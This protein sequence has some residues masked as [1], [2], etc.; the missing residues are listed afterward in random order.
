VT[1]DMATSHAYT[2]GS[3]PAE[4]ARLQGQANDLAGHTAT[5]LDK[6]E[7]PPGGRALDLGCGPAGSIA[8]LADRVGPSGFVTAIDID[9]AHV[10]MARRFVGNQGFNHVEVLQGDARATGLPSG[11]FDLVHARLLL[12]NIP[13]PEQVMAEMARLVKPGGW[14]VTD[15]ADAGARVC[16]PPL[17]AWDQLAAIFHAAYRSE[18]ADLLIGRKLTALLRDAGLVQVGADARADVYPAGHPRR[19]IL[20]D[21]VRSMSDKIVERGIASQDELARL[22]R[23][24]REHLAKPVTLIMSTLYFLAW[25]KKPVE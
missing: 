25:G 9:T 23:A 22:D 13:C 2:L 10:A 15:E 17:E 21:L 24:V 6:A 18:G 4:R 5:L 14:I 7:L 16:Y 3:N 8:L 12:V 11:A 1:T 20:P 19:T